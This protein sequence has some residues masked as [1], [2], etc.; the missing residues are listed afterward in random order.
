MNRHVSPPQAATPVEA[1]VAGFNARTP[2]SKRLAAEGRV[3]LADKSSIGPGFIRPLK[4]ALYPI[5]AERAEGPFLHDVDGN[6]YVDILMGLGTSLFGHNP[7]FIREAVQERLE[8]GFPIGPQSELAGETAELF[9]RLTGM[10]RVTF[11]NTGS[12]AVMTALRIARAATGRNTVAI[13]TNSYHG[14]FDSTL[15]TAPRL[16]YLRRGALRRH[17]AAFRLARPLLER[18]MFTGARP[19][20]R[21]TP[22]GMVRDVILLDYANPRSLDILR[23]RAGKLAAVLVE[24]VQSRCPEIQP[25]EFL[26]TLRDITAASGTALIF[27][28]MVTGFRAAPGGAQEHFG[29]EADLATYG[30]IA[31]GGLPLSLIAGRG[32]FMDHV[33][34][35]AWSFG[36]ASA[37]QVPTTFFAGTYCRHPLALAAARATARHLLEQGPALQE[38]LNARTQ[39]LVSRLEAQAQADGLPVQFT[40]FG[41]FFAI[42]LSR[43]RIAPQSVA[44]LSLLL[45]T[46]GV[47]LRL[48][49]RGGFL[50]TAHGEAE[51]DHILAAFTEGLGTLAESGLIATERTP[52]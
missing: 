43:S 28:E 42:D 50:S 10:D 52:A 3:H 44:L 22:R 9:C 36:D 17:G 15:A 11:S 34:G 20:A 7:G 27:D 51:T 30:K 32:R 6:R 25:R 31:G 39:A 8:K 37:P 21:G 49:D 35:G 40:R 5:V 41:S 16:E 12:E 19:Y 24:P 18:L 4:E 45:L 48:G 47:H 13:F 29:V 26:H 38:G 14:H 1:I 23:R 46:R 2:G 33:D